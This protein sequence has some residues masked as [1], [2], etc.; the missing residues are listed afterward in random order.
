MFGNNNFNSF[1]T[2]PQQP[3]QGG[4]FGGNKPAGGLFGAQTQGAFGQPQQQTNNTFMQPNQQA[5]GAFG[6]QPQNTILQPLV[7]PS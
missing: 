4:L 2:Q 1:G 3:A 5:Q 7:I 6:N